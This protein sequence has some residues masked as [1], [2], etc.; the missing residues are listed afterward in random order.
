MTC[1]QGYGL[2]TKR[3]KL[4]RFKTIVHSWSPM[5]PSLVHR[6]HGQSG[7]TDRQTDRHAQSNIQNIRIHIYIYI[8]TFSSK[9]Y[10]EYVT[11][12]S[13]RSSKL[14]AQIVWYRVCV[15]Y[16]YY[17]TEWG[18]Q[19]CYIIIKMCIKLRNRNVRVYDTYYATF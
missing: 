5:L 7:R 2:F 8:K 16:T 19:L 9:H 11:S 15:L 18:V 3:S 10:A 4:D 14:S 17:I 13:L 6:H 12:Q 1:H